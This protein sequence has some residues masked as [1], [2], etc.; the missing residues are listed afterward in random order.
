MF[1][2][3][4]VVGQ[5]PPGSGGFPVFLLAMLSMV[6]LPNGI[7]HSWAEEARAYSKAIAAYQD[8]RLDEAFSFAKEAIREEPEHVEAYLL[9]GELYYLQQELEKAKES[10]ERA[11]KLAPSRQDI[12]DRL[13]KLGREV[14]LEKSLS[15]SDTAPFVVRFAEGQMDLD[16]SALRQFLR[17]AYR[18]VGQQFQF[19]PD[20]PI[21]VILYPTSSFEQVKGLSHPVAGMYDGKI[22]LPM[23][24][25]SKTDESLERILWHEY[26]HAIV[27]DL[28]KGR[29]PIWFNEG[30][31]TLQETRVRPIDPRAIRETLQKRPLIPWEKLWQEDYSQGELEFRY[32]QGYL[33][34]QYLIQRWGWLE[35]VGLLKRLGQGYPMADALRAEYREDPGILEKEWLS[36]LKR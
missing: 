16:V 4:L 25:G 17:D 10:W 33:V 20:H 6:F 36:W 13:G 34:A 19:F 28:T 9:L 21:T 32:V 31:A 15:R 7:S 23:Q 14:S 26:T 11:L 30:I 8:R 12:Q 5:L 27:H 29:C 24:S 35:M 3:G 22:R 18:E 1:P 2:R